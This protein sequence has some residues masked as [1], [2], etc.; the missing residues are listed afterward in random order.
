MITLQELARLVQQAYRPERPRATRR[1]CR[2]CAAGPASP[3]SHTGGKI[4]DFK[5]AVN[6]RLSPS[7]R[8]LRAQAHTRPGTPSG[9]G[10][11]F[12]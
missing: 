1:V 5:T 2:A 4:P 10:A 11:A 8:A 3:P 9:P 12:L 7:P 6:S